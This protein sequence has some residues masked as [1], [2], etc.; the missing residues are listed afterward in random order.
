MDNPQLGYEE[1]YNRDTPAKDIW[2]PSLE[3]IESVEK[4]ARE[5]ASIDANSIWWES[6]MVIVLYQL[7]IHAEAQVSKKDVESRARNVLEK[8]PENWQTSLTLGRVLGA[9]DESITILNAT[10]DRLLKD[11]TWH[12]SLDNKRWLAE[13]YLTL[14]DKYWGTGD[15][16]EAKPVKPDHAIAKYTQSLDEYTGY[17]DRLLKVLYRYQKQELWSEIVS[18]LEKLRD[19]PTSYVGLEQGK[20]TDFEQISNSIAVSW[21]DFDMNSLAKAAKTTDSWGLF[22]DVYN[23]AIKTSPLLWW[24][25]RHKFYYGEALR[26]MKD[27]DEGFKVWEAFLEELLGN[28]KDSDVCEEFMSAYFLDPVLPELTKRALVSEFSATSRK[29]MSKSPQE[30]SALI[31]KLYGRYTGWQS[32]YSKP[33]QGLRFSRFYVLSGNIEKAKEAAREQVK[34]ALEMID[35][36]D[37]SDDWQAFIY[38]NHIFST[39]GDIPNARAATIMSA[40]ARNAEVNEYNDKMKKYEADKA[41]WDARHGVVK[42]IGVENDIVAKDNTHPIHEVDAQDK[43]DKSEQKQE[44][45]STV[46]V[47]QDGVQVKVEDAGRNQGDDAA[48]VVEEQGTQSVHD[49]AQAKAEELEPG[50]EDSTAAT[51]VVAAIASVPLAESTSIVVVQEPAAPDT[52]PQT[53]EEQDSKP[54]ENEAQESETSPT[55][56]D[57]QTTADEKPTPPIE[58]WDSLAYCDGDCEPRTKWVWPSSYWNCMDHIGNVQVRSFFY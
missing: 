34:V 29:P 25:L 5:L 56:D 14:G 12:S 49:E 7:H 52:S 18:L 26:V 46:V 11:E 20:S 13:A 19:N 43:V 3:R 22:I 37:P 6:H 36:D 51:T 4:W 58:P 53:T 16:D 10:I 42:A 9:D 15:D 50:Q 33:E 44:D 39:F 31:E 23:A 17:H 32:K 21:E 27:P 57:A 54:K 45:S 55:Q 38:L 1:M 28:E 30:Y 41:V 48:A 24:T 40:V 2:T 35:N 47:E 8:D